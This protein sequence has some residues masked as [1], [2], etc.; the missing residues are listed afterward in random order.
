[1]ETSILS[2][3]ED[4]EEEEDQADYEI[5]SSPLSSKRL[6]VSDIN[7]TRYSRDIKS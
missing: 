3:T 7:I 4:C 1:M 5:P 6:K 2:G